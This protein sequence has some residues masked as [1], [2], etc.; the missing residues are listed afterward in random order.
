MKVMPVYS[1]SPGLDYPGSQN[2]PILRTQA[3]KLNMCQQRMPKRF[4]P[5]V[6]TRLEGT[7]CAI[8]SSCPSGVIKRPQMSPDQIITV[9]VSGRGDK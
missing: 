3:G 7:I 1:I 4:R 8:E 5:S 6:L 9:N 2:M